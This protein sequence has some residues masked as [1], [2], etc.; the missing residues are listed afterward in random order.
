MEEDNH[1]RLD[2]ITWIEKGSQWFS[3]HNNFALWLW[4][5][6]QGTHDNWGYKIQEQRI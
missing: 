6:D 4:L 1:R 5:G 2:P 3:R